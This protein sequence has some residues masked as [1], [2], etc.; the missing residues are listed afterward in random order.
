MY[1]QIEQ[2]VKDRFTIDGKALLLDGVQI[3]NAGLVEVKNESDL[4]RVQNMYSNCIRHIAYETAID[5]VDDKMDIEEA[6]K[7][8]LEICKINISYRILFS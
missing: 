1:D 8:H 5:V 2:T 3:G 6:I 7:R 4:Q